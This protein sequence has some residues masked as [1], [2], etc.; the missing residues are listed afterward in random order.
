MGALATN[1][2]GLVGPLAHEIAPLLVPGRVWI[3]PVGSPVK[4]DRSPEK[5][6]AGPSPSPVFANP[7]RPRSTAGSSADAGRDRP[8]PTHPNVNYPQFRV[9]KSWAAKGCDQASVPTPSRSAL[10]QIIPCV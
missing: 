8:S 9:V 4:A 7:A 6:P 1:F 2:G 10:Y 5:P 3:S